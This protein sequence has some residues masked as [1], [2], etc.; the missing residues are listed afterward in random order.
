MYKRWSPCLVLCKDCE[1]RIIIPSV[2]LTESFASI[3]MVFPLL[4]S[5]EYISH[6]LCCEG[7]L[8]LLWWL[9]HFSFRPY[10]LYCCNCGLALF[11]SC[12]SNFLFWYVRYSSAFSILFFSWWEGVVTERSKKDET[13]L[14]VNFPGMDD[15]WCSWMNKPRVCM[16][17]C[18]WM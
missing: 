11:R 2:D 3:L 10:S 14:T 7:I 9:C 13:M 18:Y 16:L 8:V 4:S 5:N 15:W 17:F 6:L 12:Y 1:W